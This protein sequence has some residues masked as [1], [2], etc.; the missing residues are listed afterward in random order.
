MTNDELKKLAKDLIECMPPQRVE[1]I[2]MTGEMFTVE[3]LALARM[4]DRATNG[5]RA[6]LDQVAAAFKAHKP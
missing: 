4:Y 5:Q 6:A 2:G 1:I 3:A